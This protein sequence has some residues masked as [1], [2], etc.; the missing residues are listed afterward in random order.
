MQRVRKIRTLLCKLD[1]RCNRQKY[2]R[3]ELAHTKG[4]RHAALAMT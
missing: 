1:A 4:D 2:D 3:R